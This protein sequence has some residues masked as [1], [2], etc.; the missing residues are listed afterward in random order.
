MSSWCSMKLLLHV[1]RTRHCRTAT[2][3]IWSMQAENFILNVV[4]VLPQQSV[5]LGCTLHRW[6]TKVSP[7]GLAG[8]I[9]LV[10]TTPCSLVFDRHAVCLGCEIAMWQACR[11]VHPILES[12]R[13]ART[14]TMI[15]ETADCLSGISSMSS[16]KQLDVYPETAQC[17]FWNNPLST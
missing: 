15:Q 7:N 9:Y 8:V 17:L 5:V 16:W 11:P 10:M 12:S 2:G 3:S 14:M 4:E 13:Y 6:T 1:L